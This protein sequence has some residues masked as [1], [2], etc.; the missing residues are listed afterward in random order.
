MRAGHACLSVFIC[1][2]M[3]AKFA[4]TA[5]VFTLV[6]LCVDLWMDGFVDG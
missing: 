5:V 4:Y 3:H 1:T 2:C 6:S